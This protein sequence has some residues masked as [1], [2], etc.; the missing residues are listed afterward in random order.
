[1][2]S[3]PN[4]TSP[5][6]CQLKRDEESKQFIVINTHRGP[7]AYNRLSF[8]ISSAPGIFQRAMESLLQGIPGVLCYLDDVLVSGASE[9]E[10]QERLYQV[11]QVMQENGLKLKIE[12]CLIGVPQVSYLGYLIDKDGMHPTDTK[13]KAIVDAPAPRDITQ[14]KSYLGLL[15]FYRRFLPSAATLLEPLNSLMRSNTPWKWGQDQQKA[16]EASKNALLSSNVLV[17]FD[18]ALPLVVVADSS[19][20]GIGAVL[21]HEVDGIERPIYFA[22]RTLSQP[23]MNYA[24]IEKE[25]LAIVFALRKF[26]YY[27]WGQSN[28]KVVT[29]HKPL[30][31]LFSP[32]KTI[33]PMASGR[34]QRWALLLQSYSFSLH[35]RS[36]IL[37]G[38]A[39]ALSRLPIKDTESAPVSA[40]WTFLIIFWTLLLLLAL[41]LGMKLGK[42]L[43][44]QRFFVILNQDGQPVWLKILDCL[45]S[46]GDEMNCPFSMVASF[47][48]LE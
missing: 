40:D 45:R 47:G 37:L 16:F 48:V 27:L 31:G 44:C 25:A 26:H 24:Q 11:L 14:L 41:R 1:M 2:L 46:L 29:D 21:C 33:P 43:F 22:S 17:H 15:N 8:G 39:D 4:L 20:Y 36:G 3:S 35:H 7:F 13:V 30:L 38:T 19:A 5:N 9:S 32:S 23:E 42:I 6:L 34:I 18:P 12:K 10:H 28:F